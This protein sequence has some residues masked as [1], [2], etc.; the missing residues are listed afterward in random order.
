M[1]IIICMALVFLIGLW[2]GIGIGF[3]VASRRGRLLVVPLLI[4]LAMTGRAQTTNTN[5][6]TLSF[7]YPSA[8]VW[9]TDLSFQLWSTT[10]LSQPFVDVTNVPAT[11]FT[12]AIVGTNMPCTFQVVV[13][14]V[15]GTFWEVRAA[16]AFW[17]QTNVSN[18]ASNPPGAVPVAVGISHP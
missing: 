17:S 6:V 12:N 16:T 13:Q 11:M 15:P 2:I 5:T 4:L 18:I 14:P 9:P 1:E 10:N 7:N 3:S 8:L